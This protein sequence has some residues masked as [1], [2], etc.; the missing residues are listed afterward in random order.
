M[1]ARKYK[2]ISL[3]ERYKIE[4]FLQVGKK[5]SEIAK[6]LERPVSTISRE[7]KRG[8]YFDSNNYYADH[9]NKIAVLKNKVKRIE[10]KLLSNS[11]L[12]F[13]VYRGL[14]TEWTPEQIS[15]RIRLDYSK[16]LSMR[17]SYESIY[18]YIYQQPKCNKRKRLINLL[19]YSKS[20]RTGQSKRY[21]YVGTIQDRLSIDERPQEVNERKEVGHWESDLI[22][23][24]GQKSAI[25]TLV[26]RV[27]RYTIIVKLLGRDSHHVVR[28]FASALN[29]MPSDLLKSITHDNG[30]EMSRHKLFTKLTNMPVYFAHPYSSWER[31]T[32]ENTNG[33]IRRVFK[34]KTDF[35]KVTR[36]QL[37][38]MQDKLNNR[39]RKVLGWYTPNEVLAELL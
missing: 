34:K 33:L 24:K 26:E 6:L 27:T 30:V 2:R 12:L 28:A 36:K 20:K 3:E 10:S 9:A 11:R 13:Y 23:G 39:P 1:K 31:G 4:S 22:I 25:G 5:I 15:Y 29:D 16:E 21:I 18:K 14:L 17:I 32:N 7:I 35:N 38:E 8:M 37:A 19:T